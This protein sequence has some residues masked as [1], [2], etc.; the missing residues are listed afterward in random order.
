MQALFF[1]ESLEET[2]EFNG[3]WNIEREKTG[4]LFSVLG[5]SYW[6]QLLMVWDDI[7]LFFSFP[8]QEKL[9][10]ANDIWIEISERVRNEVK[11]WA[12]KVSRIFFRSLRKVRNRIWILRTT[13]SLSPPLWYGKLWLCKL[14]LCELK[15]FD[16]LE[17]VTKKI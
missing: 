1:F 12:G 13:F 16:F 5:R 3:V 11:N 10:C 17:D 6:I 2:R 4:G 15:V 14:F 7:L 8:I 9:F